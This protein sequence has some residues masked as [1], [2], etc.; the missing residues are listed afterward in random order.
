MYWPKKSKKIEARGTGHVVFVISLL[1]RG[2]FMASLFYQ[3]TINVLCKIYVLYVKK[4]VKE[5]SRNTGKANRDRNPPN[6]L[7]TLSKSEAYSFLLNVVY[8]GSGLIPTRATLPTT[9]HPDT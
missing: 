2:F 5:T 1:R 8:T 4:S 9:P 6:W 7:T 3:D